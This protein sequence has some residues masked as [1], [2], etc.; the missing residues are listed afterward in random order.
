MSETA[1]GNERHRTNPAHRPIRGG[2]L[3]ELALFAGAGGG[4]L[5]GHLL[6]WTTVCAVE[7]DA[8]AASIL[9]QRQNDGHFP[10]FPIWPDVCSFDGRPWR[11]LVDVV[12]GGFP[13]Q[14]ISAA[15]KGAGIGGK[16]SGLWSE[17]ARIVDEVRP[18]YVL[19][20]NSPLL[21]S[22]GLA[23]VQADL[24]QLGYDDQWGIVGADDAGAPHRRKRIWIRC[25][26]ADASREGLEGLAGNGRNGN[27]PGRID[28]QPLGHAA[29]ASE[30][31]RLG[32]TPG[33]GCGILWDEA[34]PGSGG[35]AIG[36]SWARFEIVHCRDGKARRFEPGSFPLADGLPGRV[37]LL[38]GYGN[39][40]VPQTA[41]EFIRAC[42][43]CLTSA[44]KM[45]K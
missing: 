17:M 6:G 19:V 12:S 21:V 25:E 1:V 33:G 31:L 26:L 7:R 13:C 16:R 28:P 35:H 43:E 27:Q 36:A 44:P 29:T 22:R 40:I 9:A 11:G 41:A 8:Y 45:P 24:A 42:E 20:E 3:N 23:L 30:S 39:A 2:T 38:R 10:P 32:D 14:D 37:G 18:R 15:G 5:G 4:L 34:Q